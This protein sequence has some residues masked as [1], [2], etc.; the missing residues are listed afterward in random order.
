MGKARIVSKKQKKIDDGLTAR[1][2]DECGRVCKSRSG[3]KAHMKI[4][5]KPAGGR[6]HHSKAAVSS[7]KD[8]EMVHEA[9]HHVQD[10]ME[11]MAELAEREEQE[12]KKEQAHV[13]QSTYNTLVARHRHLQAKLDGIIEKAL[14][15][16]PDILTTYIKHKA[17]DNECVQ[18]L[19]LMEKMAKSFEGGSHVD[20]EDETVEAI[21]TPEMHVEAAAAVDAACPPVAKPPSEDTIDVQR[22]MADGKCV[23]KDRGEP[24]CGDDSVITD[25]S[26]QPWCKRHARVAMGG[27]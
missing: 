21:P 19:M 18:M 1:T 14:K 20:S 6:K 2:C 15:A 5:A 8:A 10:A 16:S 22:L 24:F 7:I 13:L 12:A 27:N 3:L 25:D 26:G 23:W 9:T 17:A 11:D 4:H